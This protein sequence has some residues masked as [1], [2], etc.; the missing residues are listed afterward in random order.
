MHTG[1]AL[2]WRC[3]SLKLN[4]EQ[5]GGKHSCNLRTFF[6]SNCHLITIKSYCTEIMLQ[7]LPRPPRVTPA[8][9]LLRQDHFLRESGMIAKITGLFRV[10]STGPSYSA[11]IFTVETTVSS[12]CQISGHSVN[13]LRVPNC[14][15]E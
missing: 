3:W 12:N 9:M 2:R 4:L 10:P 8:R 15:L 7:C 11:I 6:P 14:C 13:V 5:A 1:T